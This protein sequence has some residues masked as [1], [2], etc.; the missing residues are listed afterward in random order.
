VAEVE[1]SGGVTDTR[2]VVSFDFDQDAAEAVVE[3]TNDFTDSV[4]RLEELIGPIVEREKLVDAVVDQAKRF[5]VDSI[6]VTTE[7]T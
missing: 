3:A 7:R 1:G 6:K 2:I 4:R 5:I